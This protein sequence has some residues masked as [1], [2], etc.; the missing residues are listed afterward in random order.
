[1]GGGR[2]GAVGAAR[3]ARGRP[4]RAGVAVFAEG[5][6]RVRNRECDHRRAGGSRLRDRPALGTADAIKVTRDDAAARRVEFTDGK[7]NAGIQA[8]SLGDNL[9][10]L[11]V[12]SAHSTG[13]DSPTTQIVERIVAVCK[14]MGVECSRGS[15][16]PPHQHQ[17]SFGVA[18]ARKFGWARLGSNQRPNDYE[19]SALT[20]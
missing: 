6:H 11:M 12:S 8:I 18:R 2:T 9:T 1:M 20:D 13:P 17:R 19:S 3:A 16:A 5:R 15:R 4:H 10:Q 14:Q 7:R